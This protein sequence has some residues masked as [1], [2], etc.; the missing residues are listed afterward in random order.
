MNG[1]LKRKKI[2]KMQAIEERNEQTLLANKIRTRKK[3][4]ITQNCECS[5][6]THAPKH[7][8]RENKEVGMKCRNRIN[9]RKAKL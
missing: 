7:F 1:V 9:I 5:T 8:Q 4:L 6:Q 2:E 3:K